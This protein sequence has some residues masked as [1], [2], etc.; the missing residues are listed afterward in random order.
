MIL[1]YAR[2]ELQLDVLLKQRV[3]SLLLLA[4]TFDVSH[5]DVVLVEVGCRSH[6]SRV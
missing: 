2:N 5:D 6:L 3:S 4:E 1:L